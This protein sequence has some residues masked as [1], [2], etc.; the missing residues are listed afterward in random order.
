MIVVG[1]NTIRL[2]TYV[3]LKTAYPLKIVAKGVKC[4]VLL[5]VGRV[6]INI[7]QQ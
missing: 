5:Y 4:S 7:D 6:Y 2:L 1:F 3:T